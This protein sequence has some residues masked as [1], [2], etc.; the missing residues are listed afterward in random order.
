MLEYLAAIAR[1]L[2]R[3]LKDRREM[4]ALLEKDERMLRD[5][6]LTRADIESALN[7][8]L[9]IAARHEAHRLARIALTLDRAR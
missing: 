9:G 6:G 7:K 5:I 3:E 8:P 2:A 4:R 1:S